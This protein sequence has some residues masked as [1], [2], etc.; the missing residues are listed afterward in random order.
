MVVTLKPFNQTR[1]PSKKAYRTIL[2]TS[3]FRLGVQILDLAMMVVAK[4]TTDMEARAW[5]LEELAGCQTI[6]LSSGEFGQFES[7][8]G[9]CYEILCPSRW[10]RTRGMVARCQEF[11]ET[12]PQWQEL[13]C[14]SETQEEKI[15]VI[16]SL[17]LHSKITGFEKPQIDIDYWNADTDPATIIVNNHVIKHMADMHLKSGGRYTPRFVQ[18]LCLFLEQNP[19]WG[20]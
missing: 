20:G 10:A 8:E 18:E 5:M 9:E 12:A 2:R 17:A 16:F 4:T 7:L 11:M 3:A 1:K 19:K 15:Y 13:F 6:P 14:W